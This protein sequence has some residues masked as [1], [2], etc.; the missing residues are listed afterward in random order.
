MS[1]KVKIF[2]IVTIVIALIIAGVTF[3]KPS[4][5]LPVVD[6]A[7]PLS[8]VTGVVPLPGAPNSINTSTDEFSKVLSTIKNITIDTSIFQNRAY[9]LLRDYPVTLG[10]DVVGRADPFAPIGSDAYAPVVENV[11][12]QTLQT[13]KITKTTAE[14]GAQVTVTAGVPTAVVFEYGTSDTFGSVTA[15]V[16]VTKSGTVLANLINLSPQTQYFVRAVAVRG[17]VTT[18]ANITSFITSK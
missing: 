13:G 4:D 12:I 6:N 2:A 16:N 10:S 14:A 1:K 7:G 15:P 18:T 5:S 17:S 3:L 8:T 9:T 11:S